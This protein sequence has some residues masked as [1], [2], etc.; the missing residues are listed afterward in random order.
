MQK[1][2][3]ERV[4]YRFQSPKGQNYMGYC[5]WQ[6]RWATAEAVANDAFAWYWHNRNGSQSLLCR[7]MQKSRR[8]QWR[9]EVLEV[10]P[11][12]RVRA[13]KTIFIKRFK[14]SE[15]YGGLNCANGRGYLVSLD[16]RKRHSQRRLGRRNGNAR[17]DPR[18]IKELSENRTSRE[19]AKILGIAQKTDQR[20]LRGE[21][22]KGKY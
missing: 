7:V 1:P 2:R 8:S 16:S 6:D 19:V 10:V 3:R 22:G 12:N 4:L 18:K 9:V 21:F 20:H 17:V 13:R 15:D 11:A 5:A 14:T